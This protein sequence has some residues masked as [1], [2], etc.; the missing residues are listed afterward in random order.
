MT[1]CHYQI[2]RSKRVQIIKLDARYQIRYMLK[3]LKYTN[4]GLSHL[5]AA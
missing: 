4:L 1:V 3:L 2:K 5:S